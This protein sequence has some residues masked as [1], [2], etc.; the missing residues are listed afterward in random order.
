[1]EAWTSDT[2]R[3]HPTTMRVPEDDDDD[4]AMAR[5]TTTTTTTMRRWVARKRRVV[6]REGEK[7]VMRLVRCAIARD[8]E[9]RE[10]RR[11][12]GNRAGCHARRAHILVW[13][14]FGGAFW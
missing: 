1:M 5:A 6:E 7:R 4:D 8:R 10:G 11:R 13:V 2:R 9:A 3:R 14:L 12:D